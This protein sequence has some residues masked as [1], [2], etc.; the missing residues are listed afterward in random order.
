[1]SIIYK[2]T[3]FIEPKRELTE[4]KLKKLVDPNTYRGL[5]IGIDSIEKIIWGIKSGLYILTGVR[6]TGKTFLALQFSRN[7]WYSSRVKTLFFS[8]EMTTDQLMQRCLQSW[9]DLTEEQFLDGKSIDKGKNLLLENFLQFYPA[10][11]GVFNYENF[12]A[13]VEQAVSQ[14]FKIFILD[15]LHLVTG[16]SSKDG[17]SILSHWANEMKKLAS[18]LEITIFCLAQP[19]K[20]NNAEKIIQTDDIKGSGSIP[21][22]ADVVLTLSR[23]RKDPKSGQVREVWFSVEKNRL[24]GKM[25]L[26]TSLY[27]KETGE[28][29]D[30]TI[31]REKPLML[32]V[33]EPQQTIKKED[34]DVIDYDLSD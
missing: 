2:P 23:E 30:G 26:G 25:Y 33:I 3:S 10:Y 5:P 8:L 29:V 17:L 27:F 32:S 4:E 31:T 15:H 11:E 22:A 24:G 34:S 19:R 21:D 20:I 12:E 1:M 28:F 18:R 13:K 9:S 14:G 7:L 16:A 6:G